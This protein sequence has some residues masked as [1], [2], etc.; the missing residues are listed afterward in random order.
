MLKEISCKHFIKNPLIF[1]N[2]LN[3]I[4]GDNYSTNSIGKSTILMIIDFVFGGGSYIEKDSG[5]VKELGQHSFNFEFIF[6]GISHYYSRNTNNH[7]FI[8]ICDKDYN[9][10][11]EINAKEYTENLKEY[12]NIKNSSS[13]RAMLNPYSRI[14]GKGNYD[15]DKPIQTHIKSKESDAIDNLIK[16]FNLYSTISENKNNIKDQ[17]ESKK[18]ITWAS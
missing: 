11:S 10:I 3:T 16:L 13:F 17:E 12:Y 1:S 6:N 8:S 18:N 7:L 4:L 2:G 5:T 14:W 15:V 9:L